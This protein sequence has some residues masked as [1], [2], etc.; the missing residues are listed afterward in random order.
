MMRRQPEPITAPACPDQ[1]GCQEL[2]TL[3]NIAGILA[4][5]GSFDQQVASVLREVL[6]I[7][8][9]DSAHLRVPDETVQGLRLLT[10]VGLGVEER[11]QEPVRRY[12]ESRSGEAFQHGEPIVANDY[13][14]ARRAGPRSAK[15]V[16]EAFGA[17]SAIWL[18]I[19]SGGR[20]IGV[21]SVSTGKADHF[22]PDRVRLLTAIADGM[23]TFLENASLREAERFHTRA[24]EVLNRAATILAG[25]GSLG[26]RVTD[27]LKEVVE[28]AG[29]WATLRLPDDNGE[30]MCVVAST[31]K[32]AL[33]VS[34]RG[35]SLPSEALKTKR[36]VIVSDYPNHPAAR[37][38]AVD[39]GVRSKGFFPVMVDG[40]AQGM[41]SVSSRD[42][43]YFTPGRVELLSTIAAGIGPSL[44]RA[45]LQ[46]LAQQRDRDRTQALEQLQLTQQQL[47]QSG[48]LAAIGEL[49]AG[50]AHEINNPLTGI[51]G[52]TQLLLL[53]ELDA[54]T[55]KG[56]EVI[57]NETLR[58][59]RI[60]QNL[61][62]FARQRKPDRGIVLVNDLVER[63][64]ELRN[65]DLKVNNIEVLLDFDPASPA[66]WGDLQQLEQV[67][68]NIV[69]NAQQA[70]AAAHGEGR[71][72][73]TTHRVEDRVLVTFTDDGPGISAKI[74]ERVFDPFFT[75]KEIGEGTGL[76]LSICYG[77]VAEH[78]GRLWVNSSHGK[79]STFTV[80]LPLTEVSP[81]SSGSRSD[82]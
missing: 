14:V 32:G 5:A 46:E 11:A 24:L 64:L 1:P 62:S 4:G 61:L 53:R 41:I 71:L 17:Q 10:S 27:L 57:Q 23:G 51:L 15:D 45:R 25:G 70:M 19:K 43:N 40:Q 55:Q 26:E 68:L 77:I 56:L 58:V 6:M 80:E 22:T 2:Q 7:S 82:G 75:T 20:P 72:A 69:N 60:V 36:P 37:K 8:E 76:G 79:G 28:V 34:S 38:A 74:I 48:K 13:G 21:I 81:V 49:V 47:V 16:I 30:N 12:G 52:N 63:T 31:R 67:F 50:V 18:P 35:D 42:P 65:Y 29:D 9:A 3:S 33:A 44:E 78:G 66:V 59:A 39:D 54:K 73:V